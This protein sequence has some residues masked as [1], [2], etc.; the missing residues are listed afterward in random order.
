MFY[1]FTYIPVGKLIAA[2]PRRTVFGEPRLLS[3]GVFLFV[4]I[5]FRQLRHVMLC[6]RCF[7]LCA[8]GGLARL[9]WALL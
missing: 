8:K 6:G 3:I 7:Y 2:V 9:L 5:Q 1:A 4:A